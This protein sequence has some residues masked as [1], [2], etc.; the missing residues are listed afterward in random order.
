MEIYKNSYVEINLETENYFISNQQL[1][2]IDKLT[3]LSF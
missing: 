3:Q 1:Q 2:I